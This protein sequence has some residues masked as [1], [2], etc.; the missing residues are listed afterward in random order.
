MQRSSGILLHISSLPNKYGFGCFSKEAY[1]FVDFLHETNQKFWQVLPINP[2]NDSGSPFQCYSVFAGNICFID[3]TEYLTEQELIKLGV[4]KLKKLNFNKIY[5]QRVNALKYIFK[6]DFKKTNLTKFVEENK[7]WLTDFA[8]FMALKEDYKTSFYNFPEKYKNYDKI[9][10]EKYE[11]KNQ[12]KINFYIFTQYLFF[13]QWERLKKY[14]QRKDI[15]IIGDI[16]FY[17]ASDSSDVWANRKEFCF[18]DNGNPLAVGGVPPDYFSEDGQ[19]W[20]NPIYN[21]E[22]MKK[23]KYK[24]WIKRF[25]HAYKF[26]DVA[27]LDHFR[28]FESF[29]AC[30]V[31]AQNAKVGKWIKGL[32]KPFFNELFKH[33]NIPQFIAEDLGIITEKVKKLIEKTGLPGM[34]VFQFAFDGN[35]KNNYF[36][37]NYI[38]NCVAYLGTHDNNTFIGFLKELDDETLTKVKLYLGKEENSTFEELTDIAISFL[39]N[40]RAEVVIL[41]IQDLLYLDENYRMNTPGTVENNWSF[42]LNKNFLSKEL[43][44]RLKQITFIANRN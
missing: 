36:P 26:F 15:K 5:E 33:K 17:P 31:K 37:H 24:W 18:D 12:N 9:A 2:T 7:F 39:M 30:P 20:G 6:R 38:N 29:W 32:G 35:K 42:V 41:T 22:Y 4:K 10:I 3:L 19:L 34:K 16:A 11:L 1:D 23:N 21:V 25:K 27:R 14:A 28:G 8:I 13:N 44:H 40:S 43:I